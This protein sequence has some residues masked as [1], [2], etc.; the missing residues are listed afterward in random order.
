MCRT[1]GNPDNHDNNGHKKFHI[2]VL[3]PDKTST[4][5]DG[6]FECTYG[7]ALVQQATSLLPEKVVMLV[8][9][10]G[11]GK[12]TL[13]NRLV[14]HIFGV[15][16]TDNFRFQL[17]VEQGLSQ[18]VS[19]TKCI[20]KYII[21]KSNL[22]YKLVIIDTPGLG[23][24]GGEKEDEKNISRIKNLFESNTI[25]S[26]DAI[27][28]VS[29]YN[30]QRL[31]SYLSYI[32]YKVVMIFGVNVYE[33]FFV[34]AT[35]CDSVYDKNNCIKPAP[36]LI[37]FQAADIPFKNSFPFN[38][39]DIFME[40]VDK[41]HKT[42]N[43]SYWKT[44]SISFALFFHELDQTLP[45]SLTTSRDILIKQH[46]ILH[47]QLPD[48]VRKLKNSVHMI[49]EC[50]EDLNAIKSDIENSMNP[51]FTYK[52]T[53]EKEVME[54]I[55]EPDVYCSRCEKCDRVCHY[56]C[57]IG[58]DGNLWWCKTI[59]WFNL[60]FRMHCIVCEDKCSWK[61]HKCYKQRPVRRTVEEVRTNDYLKQK[62]L[63]EPGDTSGDLR[64]SCEEK[65][66]SVY[67]ALL[68]DLES[69]QQCID[70]ISNKCLSKVSTTP[71]KNISN[72]TLEKYIS[73]IIQKERED[74]ED[75]FIKR[76]TVLENLITSMKKADIYEDFK[77]AS[78]EEK[79]QLAKQ[80]FKGIC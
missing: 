49:D 68:K 25:Q 55:D 72:T 77:K 62:Y 15:K 1:N 54:D 69:I 24:T 44:S 20:T 13:I 58:K 42:L 12:S 29:S 23:D 78:N 40:P 70:F 2:Y 9:A 79:V 66:V 16:Y 39:K 30:D 6:V 47:A 14:N 67:G 10:T 37:T 56:P 8:G 4:V 17:I 21:Y 57:T 45:V 59:S 73:D 48:F 34:M 36:T 41:S 18:T 63:S 51:G 27:C 76:I 80:C 19:Q 5:A 38:N 31:T 71:E 28:F 32:L 64:K 26:I 53:V 7:T 74:R 33:N 35:F 46:N 11:T 75:G 60:Q 3:E 52:V 65:M 43:Y 50:L 61:D 22:L